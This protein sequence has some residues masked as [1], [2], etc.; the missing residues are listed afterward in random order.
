M[1]GVKVVSSKTVAMYRCRRF[2]AFFVPTQGVLDFVQFRLP[3]PLLEE[4][5]QTCLA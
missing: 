4:V 2:V 5:L 3:T 1:S